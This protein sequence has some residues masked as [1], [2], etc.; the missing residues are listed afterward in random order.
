MGAGQAA[1]RPYKGYLGKLCRAGQ[2]AIA[3]AVYKSTSK[4]NMKGEVIRTKGQ[5]TQCSWEVCKA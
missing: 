3:L 5:G 1:K 2:L 4:I